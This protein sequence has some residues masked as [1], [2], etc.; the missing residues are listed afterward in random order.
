MAELTRS[1]KLFIGETTAPVLDPR[2]GKVKRGY[3]WALAGEL[4][5]KHAV[6]IL[7]GFDVIPQTPLR[8]MLHLPVGQW[9]AI[10]ATNH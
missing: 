4:Y 6:D 7:K 5:G 1:T 2:E 10:S 3:F 8:R 9:L